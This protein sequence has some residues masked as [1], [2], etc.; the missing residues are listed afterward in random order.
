MLKSGFRTWTHVNWDFTDRCEGSKR[1]HVPYSQ[2]VPLY[3]GTQLQL[4]VSIWL[5]HVAPFWQGELLHSFISETGNVEIIIMSKFSEKRSSNRRSRW[6]GKYQREI[7]ITR[8]KVVL[9]YLHKDRSLQ[10]IFVTILINL[11]LKVDRSKNDL[12]RPSS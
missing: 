4:Y 1:F 9:L 11:N 3:P 5:R 8:N 7:K 10:H 6:T 12:T 2:S